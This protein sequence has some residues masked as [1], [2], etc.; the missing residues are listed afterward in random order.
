MC[1]KYAKL[2]DSVSYSTFLD[3]LDSMGGFIENVDFFVDVAFRMDAWE[4]S[5]HFI[6]DQIEKA[7]K[8]LSEIEERALEEPA[9][10]SKESKEVTKPKSIFEDPRFSEYVAQIKIDGHDP[11]DILE[12]WLKEHS[13]E[14]LEDD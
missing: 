5:A 14:F 6:H 9:G 12:S 8:E 4:K 1:F 7:K 2:K 3:L 11:V 13:P 10:D